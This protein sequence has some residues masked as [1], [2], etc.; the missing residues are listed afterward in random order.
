[1]HQE[2]ERVLQCIN[3]KIAL[4]RLRYVSHVQHMSRCMNKITV[5]APQNNCNSVIRAVCRRWLVG[6]LGLNDRHRLS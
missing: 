4:K 6:Y 2:R 5:T 3:N 1:M